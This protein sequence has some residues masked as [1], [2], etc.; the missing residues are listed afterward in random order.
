[1]HVVLGA[2]GGIGGAVVRE[3]AARGYPTRAVG[4]SL[5]RDLPHGVQG[6]AVDVSTSGGAARAC[7]GAAAVYHCAQPAY[8]RWADEFLP[9]TETVA[10]AAG[11]AGARLVLADN[12]YMYG[13]VDGALREDTPLHPVGRKGRTR[14]EMARRLLE[15]HAAGEV[16]V[17]IGRASDYCGP[18]GLQST[19]GKT[20]SEPAL[21]G[22]RARWVGR[23]DVPH[24]LHYLGD[25]ARGLVTLGE[26]EEARGQVWHLPRGR[27]A[28]GKAVPRARIRC[29]WN[30]A[31]DRPS[32]PRHDPPRRRLLA[33]HP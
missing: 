24:T 15:R 10:T 12:L 28:Y 13:P 1:M 26:R 30:A 20:V 32:L 8:T 5:P 6:V 29:G 33:A 27:A 4:R 22:K 17:V 25:V 9:L 18:G 14:A 16:E 2:S 7:E 31:A 11:A 21:A 19:A 3:L 23:L